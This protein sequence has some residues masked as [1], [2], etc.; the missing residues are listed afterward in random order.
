MSEQGLSLLW[1]Q[2]CKQRRQACVGILAVGKIGHALEVVVL[3]RERL[4]SQ[5]LEGSRFDAPSSCSIDELVPSDRE[6]PSGGR[7]MAARAVAPYG[8]Q[9]SRERLGHQVRRGLRILNPDREV[10]Q[11][12]LRVAAVEGGDR[13]R[14]LSRGDQLTIGIVNRSHHGFK[15]TKARIV[16]GRASLPSAPMTRPPAGGPR[17]AVV[18]FDAV[19]LALVDRLIGEGR[20]PVLAGLRDAGRWTPLSGSARH[21]EGSSATTLHSGLPPG[22]HGVYHPFA[23]SAEHQGL[24]LRRATDVPEAVWTRLG[25]HGR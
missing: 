11:D 22:A 17:L 5:S 13:L 23:W 15:R 16:P 21:L 24:R 25:R 8:E 2:I 1:W 19:N 14:V 7:P 3:E 10:A 6:E 12:V 20:L 4:E 18:Q 9:S